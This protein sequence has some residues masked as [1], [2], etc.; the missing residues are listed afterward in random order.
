MLANAAI[1]DRD[2]HL[3]HRHIQMSP[4]LCI[5]SITQKYFLL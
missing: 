2:S 1:E 4:Y 5:K 3:F